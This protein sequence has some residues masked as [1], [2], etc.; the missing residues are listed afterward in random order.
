MGNPNAQL[1]IILNNTGG[2]R[3]RI[4]RLSLSFKRAGEPEF[5][6]TGG[7]YLNAPS[8]KES[9]LLTPFSLKPGDEWGHIVHFFMEYSQH[10]QRL[11]K[12]IESTLKKDVRA[13]LDELPEEPGPN[14][15]PVVGEIENVSPVLDFFNR[16]FKWFAGEYEV[17]LSVT[18]EIPNVMTSKR[19]RTTI[20]ESDSR[21]M[22]EFKKDYPTGRGLWWGPDEPGVILELVD[23]T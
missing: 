1:H 4:K 22:E 21:D 9:I 18:A 16:K 14:S 13:K 10:D 11:Y 3:V 23:K 8:D 19:M 6:L 15:V 20:F 7:N 17:V 5:T 2:R 12:A